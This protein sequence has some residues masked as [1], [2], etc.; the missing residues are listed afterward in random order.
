M[1]KRMGGGNLPLYSTMNTSG[2]ISLLQNRF[3]EEEIIPIQIHADEI[4]LSRA[5]LSH[6]TLRKFH[7]VVESDPLV[8]EMKLP[9]GFTNPDA[10]VAP[11]IP[12]PAPPMHQQLYGIVFQAVATAVFQKDTIIY[13]YALKD[14]A[15]DAV[16]SF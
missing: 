15:G 7:A 16:S 2:P 1:V 4:Y 10:Q 3:D 11:P 6:A 5:D 8:L 9:A 12:Y 14:C 13:F